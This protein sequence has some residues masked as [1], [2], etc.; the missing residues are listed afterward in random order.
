MA[1]TLRLHGYTEL[2]VALKDAPKK[3]RKAVRDDLRE[4]G[5][6]VQADAV[7]RLGK[8]SADSAAGLKTI[9]RQ[10]GVSVEQTRRKVTGRRPDWGATQMNKVLIPALD[11]KRGEVER[12]LEETLDRL[13]ARF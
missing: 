5:K 9:V 3:E 8:L 6:I 12:S 4:A 13:S 2:L 1:Q 10:R 11:E 7:I